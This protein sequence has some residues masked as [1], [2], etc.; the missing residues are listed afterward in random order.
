LEKNEE[1]RSVQDVNYTEFEEHMGIATAKTL[2][3][4]S[5]TPEHR[6]R[7]LTYITSL[8][9]WDFSARND[10]IDL[11]RIRDNVDE[12]LHELKELS[13]HR[14]GN[15]LPMEIETHRQLSMGLQERQLRS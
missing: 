10:M 7:L 4:Q 15:L 5:P 1:M 2:L 11:Y 8:D 12:A 6:L 9:P 3:N 13:A 14:G